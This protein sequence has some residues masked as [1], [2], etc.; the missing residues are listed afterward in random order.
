MVICTPVSIS[1]EMFLLLHLLLLVSSL[2]TNP[3]NLKQ[4]WQF[5]KLWAK[6]ETSL[7]KHYVSCVS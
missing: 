7:R 1:D 5:L 3:M 4:K 2:I 6:Q